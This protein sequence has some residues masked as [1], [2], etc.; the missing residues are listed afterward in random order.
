MMGGVKKGEKKAG[1]L[2]FSQPEQERKTSFGG[3]ISYVEAY[4]GI[5]QNSTAK[6]AQ[7]GP[8]P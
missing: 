1:L 7:P 3:R 5:K 6:G 4:A 2:N 8:T